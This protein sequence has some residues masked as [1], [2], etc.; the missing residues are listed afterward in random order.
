LATLGVEKHDHAAMELLRG[1]IG[2][3]GS[4][5]RP[6]HHFIQIFKKTRSLKMLG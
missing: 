3:D 2:F 1:K 4:E 6:N 5:I